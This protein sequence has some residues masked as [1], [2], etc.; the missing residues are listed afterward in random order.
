MKYREICKVMHEWLLPIR[1][2]EFPEWKYEYPLP[3]QIYRCNVQSYVKEWTN[4]L[5]SDIDIKSSLTLCWH[6]AGYQ[7]ILWNTDLHFF[8]KILIEG[9]RSNVKYATKIDNIHLQSHKSRFKGPESPRRHML[10]NS[11]VDF[12]W[13]VAFWG[14]QN[15]PCLKLVEIF[16]FRVNCTIPFGFNLFWHFV[17][18]TFPLLRLLRLAIDYRWGSKLRIWS[19]SLI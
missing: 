10:P 3:Q 1:A 16:I 9:F 13:F 15:C 8:L 7:M 19:I 5:S 12:G 14:H 17:D 4:P 2:L 18:V 6:F 11:T